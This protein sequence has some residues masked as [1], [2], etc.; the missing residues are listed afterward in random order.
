MN[1]IVREATPDDSLHIA[2]Y[3]TS[4]S[5]TYWLN[6]GVD[7]DKL[8]SQEFWLNR[9]REE[10]NKP[11]AKKQLF[12]LIWEF[13]GQPVGHSNVNKIK[14]GEEAEMHLHIWTQENT[15]KGIGLEFLK[16]SVPLYFEKLQISKLYCQPYAKNPAANKVITK[17][18]FEFIQNYKPDPVGWIHL[19]EYMNRYVLPYEKFKTL[20]YEENSIASQ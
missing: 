1:I 18:G 17:L 15:R 9:L 13:D 12:F 10:F 16:Q 20:D 19:D 3:F 7:P 4:R 2:K 14:F 8:P 6:M 5:N 11:F